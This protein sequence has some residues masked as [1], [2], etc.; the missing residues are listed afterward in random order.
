MRVPLSDDKSKPQHLKVYM[1]AEGKI[2]KTTH[3]AASCL[4]A[5]PHQKKGLV[6][7]PKHLHIITIDSNAV[8]GLGAFI[9]KVCGRPAEY[10]DASVYPMQ[11]A[12][13]K[14][15]DSTTDWDYSFFNSSVQIVSEVLSNI[16]KE[17]GVH[18]VIVS[19]LTG[20]AEALIRGM[21][22]P[23]NSAKKGGGMDMSKWQD[24]ARQ[25]TELRNKLHSDAA[26]VFWE[27]HVTRAKTEDGKEE[28]GVSGKT[29]ANF[30]FNVDYVFRMRREL[31][32][33][34]A[35]TEVEKVYVDTRP[36]LDF[37]SSGRGVTGVLGAKEYD[38]VEVAE[39]LGL[40]VGGYGA[41]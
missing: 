10:L 12:A 6:T 2:G 1:V 4:G 32:V 37:T 19:S 17:P 21:A 20:W 16:R 31:N 13:R 5:L 28:S 25:L 40:K 23:P 41:K 7:S 35:G 11:D 38:L 27:G 15:S 18:A 33:K 36:T 22:G 3:L 14:V 9:T 26:H 29:G 34:Y 24:Y 30:G 8:G 39:K